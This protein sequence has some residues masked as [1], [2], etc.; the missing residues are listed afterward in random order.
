M[1]L[2]KLPQKRSDDIEYIDLRPSL[3]YSKYRYR[4]RVYLTG[5][6]SIWFC[7]S[8]DEV[9]TK[10][11]KSSRFKGADTAKLKDFYIWH[12]INSKTKPKQCTIRLE[13]N[14]GAIFSNDLNF[15]KD[16]EK[17][18][19]K[20]DYTEVDESIPSGVKYF[21]KEPKYK[22]RFYLKSKRVSDDFPE[23][24]K[25]FVDT[26]KDTN[27]VII[28]SQGLRTWY[29]SDNNPS[30]YISWRRRYCSSSYFIDCNEESTITLFMLMFDSMVS[31]RYKLEKRPE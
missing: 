29:L 8:V 12:S 19:A 30:R 17:I 6:T 25:E 11:K 31:R 26:Y 23:K 22:Y 9:E 3:Y 16:L 15:L 27:T 10:V 1:A 28:P 18:G 13:G 20:I 5:I 24:L 4:A 7:N 2:S 14:V 21:V